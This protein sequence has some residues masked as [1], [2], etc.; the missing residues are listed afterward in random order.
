MHLCASLGKLATTKVA[1]Q[2][3]AAVRSGQTLVAV[4]AGWAKD[5]RRLGRIAAESA[6]VAKDAPGLGL[7][8]AGASVTIVLVVVKL[9]RC[10]YSTS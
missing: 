1:G 4:S 8:P 10:I 3:V 7:R 6:S 5:D 9:S 2:P